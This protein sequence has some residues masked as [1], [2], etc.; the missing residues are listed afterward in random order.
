MAV[1]RCN[2]EDLERIAKSTGATIVSSL[3]DLDG[4]ESF[5][6]SLLGHAEEVA[7]ERFGDNECLLIVGPRA[8]PAASIILRGANSLMLDEMERSMH[9]ALCAVKRTL[10]SGSVVPGGGAVETALSIYLENFATTI[11]SR[12][13][14]AVADF[15]D[16]L[17]AIPKTLAINAG[18]DSM[19]LVSRLRAMHFAAQSAPVD[20]VRTRDL[21]WTGLDLVS[22][23]VRDSIA[24]GILEPAM[25]KVRALKSATEAAI[26]I[27]RIDDMM[28]IAPEKRPENEDECQ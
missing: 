24:A 25:S 22:G 13:Q 7:Q 15:G 19:E 28:T 18:K 21:K 5:D 8:S 4:N 17:L 11:A 9:D 23:K 16:A 14:M 1:R 12:E 3:A 27:L 10:E 20:D 2:K 26:S 6:S